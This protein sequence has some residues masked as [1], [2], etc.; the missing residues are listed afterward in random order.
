[1]ANRQAISAFVNG[2]FLALLVLGGVLY[3]YGDRL[4]KPTAP[5]GERLAWETAATRDKLTREFVWTAT[6]QGPLGA[7]Q[8]FRLRL[9]GQTCTLDAI[10]DDEGVAVRET[11]APGE[12][13]ELGKAAWGRGLS[14]GDRLRFVKTRDAAGIF[15]NDR[16]VLFAPCAI[17]EWRHCSW[18]L[19]GMDKSFAKLSFQKVAPLFFSDDFMHAEGELG[20]WQTVTGTWTVHSVQN[21]IRSA[22]P[23]SLVGKGDNALAVAGYWFWRNYEITC[24]AHPLPGSAFG[25]FFCYQGGDNTYALTWT[26]EGR[27]TAATMKL[28]RVSGESQKT[29]ARR[30][31]PFVDTSWFRLR[32]CQIEGLLTVAVDDRLVLQVIDPDPLLGG[33]VGLWTSG[34][35]GTVFDD[36][37]VKPVSTF[38]CDF[39]GQKAFL[40]RVLHSAGALAD[41]HVAGRGLRLVATEGELDVRGIST[42]NVEVTANVDGLRGLPGSLELRARQNGGEYVAFRVTGPK[43]A[44]TAEIAAKRGG[45]E[46]SLA[47][48]ALKT[49]PDSAVLGFHTQGNEAWGTIDGETVCF[50]T[51]V[52]DV[53]KGICGLR[54][55]DA[56]RDVVL[57][58][59]SMSPQIDMPSIANRVETFTREESMSNWSSP[60]AEWVSVTD[61]GSTVFWHRSDFWQD[62]SVRADLLALRK[63]PLGKEHGVVLRGLHR[64]EEGS[65]DCQ[66]RL[67]VSRAGDAPELQLSLDTSPVLRQPLA[68]DPLSI[69]LEKR[70]RRLFVRVDEVVVWH[71]ELPNG[72]DTLTRVGRFGTG[73]EDAWAEAID[74]RATGV[75]S[76]SFKRAPTDWIPVTG[77]WK[78]TNRWQCDPR[79]SFYSGVQRGGVACNWNKRRHGENVTVEFFAGPKMD[80]ERG[81]HYQYAADL[82]AVI[83]ADGVDVSSGYSFMFGGWD[84]H[85][86]YIV[87]RSKTMQENPSVI[88]PRQSSTHRRWF[89]IKLRKWGNTLMYWVD[90]NRVATVDDAAPLRGDRL[91]LWT[92]DNGMMVSQ[93]RVCTDSEFDVAP[94]PPQATRIPKTPYD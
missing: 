70:N 8:Q 53:G 14:E 48:V 21:P 84:D 42:E 1:M 25:L 80:R 31:L 17:E 43:P 91:G 74:I 18:D 68:R 47:R 45:V 23:F 59:F 4:F 85:G 38:D 46:L 7:G 16:R 50:A 90:G 24:S 52:P 57:R 39:T 78:V 29:I 34:D 56:V 58:R 62:V 88:I 15:L 73:A 67:I 54:A 26:P 51:E 44:L 87:R 82:N 89:H 37:Q 33:K 41:G 10:G 81:G 6:L 75:R 77:E 13:R 66:A 20:E 49:I 55:D 60:E 27:T 86:S 22:N 12:H 79:W 36:L 64:G 63:Q 94:V 76:Y 9:L 83:C 72:L 40:P 69:Q 19:V 11:T 28:I 65:D 35:E 5:R 30:A 2:A 32:V 71:D 92:W 93:V 3:F 61:G